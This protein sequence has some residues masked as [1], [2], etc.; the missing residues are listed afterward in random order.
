MSTSPND[1]DREAGRLHDF[2]YDQVLLRTMS[3][4]RST[5]VNISTS[6]VTTAIFTLFAFGL[7][8]GGTSF[9]WAYALGFAVLLLVTLM[10]A[11]LGSDMPIA[12]ALYQWASRVVGPKYGYVSAWIYIAAQIGITGAVAYGIAPFVGSL[13]N[14]ELTV[15]QTQLMAIA[16]VVVCLAINLVGVRVASAV[17]SLGAAA[18]VA[19]MLVL[20]VVLLV[21]GWGNQSPSIL[22]ES[23]G[24]PD[25]SAFLPVALATM[26]FGS[27]AYTGIEMTTDMA[28]ETKDASRVIPRAAIGSLV[29]TFVVGMVFLVVAV[30]AIPGDSV[31]AS[32]N[33]LQAI[34]EGNTSAAFYK[35]MLIVVIVAVF[36]CTIANQ[37]LT[38]RAIF[39]LARDGKAPGAK[40][41][42][43]VPQSTRVPSVALA[44]VTVL[45]V[46]LLLFTDAIA[47]IAVAALTALFV[48]Y[49]MVI[50]AQLVQR[51]RGRW[52]PRGWNLGRHSTTV[53]V[54][55]AV[56]GTALTLNIAWPR[57]EGIAWYNKWSGFLYVGVAIVL[58]LAYYGLG[59]RKVREA[60]ERPLAGSGAASSGVAA[61][62]PAPAL[63]G[64]TPASETAAS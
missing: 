55:A 47:T 59:G 64:A 61:P 56:L 30:L 11:E 58:A 54:L 16:I 15:G 23:H 5:L 2:G 20:T 13:F 10:F 26:L 35:V 41:L 44:V 3:G 7:L 6:S 45:T 8:T 46:I 32:A 24:L 38:A 4:L 36:A 60:I 19:G 53:N 27:W 48:V 9:V 22:F 25:G 42:M 37:A 40:A 51:V 62:A 29:T 1:G 14:W 43:K 31:F 39:S 28:E 63:H 33:P 34:I 18:E 17:A 49:M 12:G 21:A 50:W 52:A 57:G